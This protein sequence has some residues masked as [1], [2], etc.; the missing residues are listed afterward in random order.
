MVSWDEMWVSWDDHP[1]NFMGWWYMNSQVASFVGFQ[2]GLGSFFFFF[3]KQDP[4]VSVS[5]K[6][7]YFL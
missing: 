7:C 4:T 2:M 5:V 3:F 1:M 6:L